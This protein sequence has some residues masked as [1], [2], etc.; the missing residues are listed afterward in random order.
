MKSRT[1]LSL[2]LLILSLFL[3]GCAG[4]RGIVK[5]SPDTYTLSRTDKGG[6]FDDISNTKA[7]IAREADEFAANQRKV[8]VP[9]TMKETPMSIQGF[10]SVEYQFKILDK[11]DPE[12]QA[13]NERKKMVSALG[14]PAH[15]PFYSATQTQREQQRDIYTEL[16]KLDELRKRGILTDAEFDS[17]KKKVLDSN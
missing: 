7:D 17:Q 11:T 13:I 1:I 4:G 15:A 10:T 2:T 9:V 3:T 8:A 14:K 16:T 5:I 12:V 6:S